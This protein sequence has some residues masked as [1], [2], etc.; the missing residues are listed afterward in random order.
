MEPRQSRQTQR[1]SHAR[2]LFVAVGL[3]ALV[4]GALTNI[5]RA[6]DVQAS[7]Y[8]I[9]AAY[10]CKFAAYVEW[11]AASASEA[12]APVVIG[13]IASDAVAAE[14]TSTLQGQSVG[15]RPIVV[16]R[17]DPHGRLDGLNILFIARTHSARL[18][19][20]LAALQGKPVLTVTESDAPGDSSSM[21]KFVV[22]DD[23]VKFDVALPLVLH[24][25]LKISARLLAVA[26]VVTGRDS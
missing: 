5:A 23:K 7:E 20:A 8:Q 9:K 24:S 17:I 18:P 10:L 25:G 12:T 11:P 3:S 14:M 4:A 26:H 19:E 6:G 2:R 1:V 13:L 16:R 21:V 22:I 15:D